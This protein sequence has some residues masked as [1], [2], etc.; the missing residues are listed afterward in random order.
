M[1]KQLLLFCFL[2]LHTCTFA[3]LPGFRLERMLGAPIDFPQDIQVGPDGT[4]HVLD[5]TGL[6]QLDA[7][8][9][10]L[11]TIPLRSRTRAPDY[12]SLTLDHRRH[13]FVLNREQGF[14]R[15]YGATGD[16]LAQ[17]GQTGT[18]PGQFRQPEGIAADA[19][20]NLYVADTDNNRL[21]K[22][23][24]TGQVQWVY[25][26]TGAQ[27]LVQPADVQLAPDGSV[28]V[29]NKNYTAVRLSPAGQLL[30][31]LSLRLPGNPTYD[32]TIGLEIDA[33]GSLYVVSS[34]L[35]AIQ[36]YSAKG[37]HLG[38]FG[39]GSGSYGGVHMALGLD[40]AGNVY[41]LDAYDREPSNSYSSIRKLSPG[42]DVLGR[43]GNA[44]VFGNRMRQDEAGNIYYLAY[45]QPRIV[46]MS[47]AGQQ[48]AVTDG[49]GQGSGP[50]TGVLTSF[51]VDRYGS[52]YVLEGLNSVPCVQKFDA[53]GRFT[54]KISL[55]N[56][57]TNP[58]GYM[59]S[60]VAVDA[61]GNL[62]VLDYYSGVRKYSAQGQFLQ[63]IG[64]GG[65]GS[66]P[67]PGQFY[68]PRGLVLDYRGNVYVSDGA[69]HRVQKFSSSGQ[70]LREFL[71]K[72]PP[73][74]Q[75]SP[76]LSPGDAGLAVDGAGNV[77]ASIGRNDYITMFEGNSNRQVK[78]DI[79]ASPSLITINQSG[80]WLTCARWGHD[81]LRFYT[82][83]TLPFQNYITGKVFQDLNNDCLQQLNEPALP[84]MLVTAE[85]GGAYGLTDENGVYTLAVDTG[86]YTVRQLL[87]P[88]QPGKVVQQ[89]CAGPATV[90][91]HAY[92]R[93]ETGPDFGNQISTSPFLTVNVSSDRRRR[94]FRS[95]TAVS[96]ANTGFA[97]SSDAT[98]TVALPAEVAFIKADIPYTRNAAGHYV[99][100]VGPLQPNQ[101]GTIHIQDSVSCGNPAVRGLTVCTRAWIQ[102]VSSYPAPL[103]WNG[104]S[105]A[106]TGHV[107]AGNQVRFVVRNQGS[108]PTTD[109]LGLRI[110]QDAELALLRRISLAAGDSLVLRWSA[111]RPVVRV[112]ADQPA[113][114]PHGRLASATVEIAALRTGNQPSPAM[115]AMPPDALPPEAAADCQPILDSFD[116]NDKQVVPEGVTAQRYTPT[117]EALRY[118]IRFQNTGTDVAYRV[119][120]VDTLAAGL[121]IST[122]Q[123]GAVSHPYR[124][125][126]TGRPRPV[127]TFTFE[128]IM[129]PDSA[130][131][132][133]GSNGFVQFSLRPKAGLP[134]RTRIDNAADI[135]FDYNEPVRT[136]TTTNRIYDVPLRVEP[137]VALSYPGVLAAPAITAV[138]PVQGRA[139][140]LVTLT[141]YNFAADATTNRV[142]FNGFATPVLSTTGGSLTVRVPAGATSGPL[143][144]TT[145]DG[146]TRT[147]ASFIVFQPPTLVSVVPHEGRPG[148]LVTVT[149]THFSALAAQDTVTFN[150]VPA[151]ILQ[152]SSGSLQVEVPTGTTSG[153]ISVRTL[154]GQISSAQPFI[155]WLPPTISGTVPGRARTGASVLL[156]GTNFAESPTRNTVLF[157][158]NQ[159]ATVLQAS[160]TR[161]LVRVPA[162][163][164]AGAI[165]VETPGGQTHTPT[166]FSLIPAPVITGFSPIQGPVGTT[167]TLSGRNFLEENRPD[168]ILLAGRVARIVRATATT[169]EVLVPR[170]AS[171]G[172]LTVAGAG[173]RGQSAGAFSVQA[174]PLA[175]AVTLYPNPAATQVTVSWQHAD[176]IVERV[177]VYDAL[178][179]LAATAVVSSAV[180]SE[181]TVSLA[182]CQAGLYTVLIDTPAGRV[183]KRLARL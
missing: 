1:E 94:C 85:P 156:T 129:L 87:P 174:L 145:A 21:Q 68:A 38:A 116:P 77:Y 13:I 154:G 146:T 183:V 144:L 12:R 16:S 162:Q 9:R 4:M 136:N 74:F 168:T 108:G 111:T 25:A 163:A 91:F 117:A 63:M 123:V 50:F 127:L 110:Y 28:Y 95:T 64:A 36:R 134:P 83:T 141:G 98:V 78:L 49:V 175:E 176:F 15:Q 133:A 178:G 131:N 182:H 170:G 173:G 30:E 3:Q 119:V 41:A 106:V 44:G 61:G 10:F 179:R 6:I 45:N 57:Q 75:G 125:T 159:P 151:R 115:R 8:G 81:V 113:N 18:A 65:S 52:V 153:S 143:T 164:Q 70:L 135:F 29:L 32:T 114:H 59:P 126:V 42:G 80:T 66:G 19:D 86:T 161:L 109:S 73:S 20:G 33:A 165:R 14:V 51:A 166:A 62:Y 2:L 122:L 155:I 82:P 139:G 167:I 172:T 158:G 171:T 103:G 5:R 27:A 11:R 90:A 132:Q 142:W 67:G 101:S 177:R 26:P 47:P 105:M 120:V 53:Q 58:N 56:P 7:A 88:P 150:G 48:L 102:P 181:L 69:G 54:G 89:L 104:A 149:G 147:A 140:T 121:D 180:A 43:W 55:P 24:P 96:Y 137:T 22:L 157:G 169:A 40:A 84:Y 76:Y 93:T 130:R 39:A 72:F 92:G 34:R 37:V 79:G 100:Q 60:D 17:F 124:L 23:S 107:V 112:E 152:A 138:V 148:T 128:G 31:T 71:S 46:K 97:P 160:T 35:A 118:K 99:F